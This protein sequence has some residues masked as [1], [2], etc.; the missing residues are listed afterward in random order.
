MF[1]S[2]FVG[3]RARLTQSAIGYFC[4]VSPEHLK[5]CPAFLGTQQQAS[6]SLF[7]CDAIKVEEI[8]IGRADQSSVMAIWR[9]FSSI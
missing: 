7:H 6:D 8:L 4:F 5:S 2:N 1:I 3:P 9:K